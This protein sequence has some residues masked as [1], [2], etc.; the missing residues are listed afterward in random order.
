M[1]GFEGLKLSSDGLVPN[2]PRSREE[3]NNVLLEFVRAVDAGKDIP[4]ELLTY[5]RDGVARYAGGDKTPWK[6]ERGNGIKGSPIV[7]AE[8]IFNAEILPRL[9]AFMEGAKYV[10]VPRDQLSRKQ[11]EGAHNSGRLCAAKSY[12]KAGG[13]RAEEI[14]KHIHALAKEHGLPD[15]DVEILEG[16]DRVDDQH[17]AGFLSGCGNRAVKR[18]KANT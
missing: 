4:R 12:L 14:T 1:M 13:K 3:V 9:K 17:H 8:M 6:A 18:E 15:G 11:S 7:D 16:G 2:D 5:V 10:P